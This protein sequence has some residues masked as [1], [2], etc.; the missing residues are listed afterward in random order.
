M[1]RADFEQ[2]DELWTPV[3]T[4]NMYLQILTFE[5]GCLSFEL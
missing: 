5:D 4:T 1:S 3:T 2:V